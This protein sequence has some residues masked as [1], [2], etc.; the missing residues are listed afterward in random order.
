MTDVAHAGMGV[1]IGMLGGNQETREALEK[2]VGK[3]IDRLEMGGDET[4]V[5]RFDDGHR[6]TLRDDGQSCCEHRHTSTDDDLKPASGAT[7]L[8]AEIA[9]A[10]SRSRDEEDRGYGDHD[11]QFLRI[12]TSEGI[13]TFVNHNEHNGYYGGFW[14]VANYSEGN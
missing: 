9:S 2:A 5:L 7:F 13:F 8:G 6:L 14:I 11:Q 10:D 3:K 1:L 12:K 4:I